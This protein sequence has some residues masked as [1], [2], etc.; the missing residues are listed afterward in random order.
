MCHE[1]H[2]E[3]AEREGEI[4]NIGKAGEILVEAICHSCA[5]IRLPRTISMPISSF[6][7]FVARISDLLLLE[8]GAA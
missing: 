6:V 2:E 4:M 3:N 8:R 7:T 1:E 5:I